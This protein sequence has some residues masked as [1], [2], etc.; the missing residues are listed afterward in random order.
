MQRGKA[1]AIKACKTTLIRCL[2]FLKEPGEGCM[3]RCGL[4][5]RCGAK[6]GGH[7]IAHSI[8]KL[9]Q[10]ARMVFQNFSLF[11]HMRALGNVI[12]GPL[13]VR[14]VPRAQAMDIGERLR[15]QVGLLDKRNTYLARLL[16]EQKQRVASA[17]ALAMEY[18]VVLFD[19]PTSALDSELHEE[20]R[21]TLSAVTLESITMIV[22]THEN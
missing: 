22:V 2:N 3:R 15:E 8:R 19:E 21:Q 12:E 7:A 11:L 13:T 10:R 6:A 17:R 14:R 16:G 9:R 18:E 5:M 4:A 20:G 1:V